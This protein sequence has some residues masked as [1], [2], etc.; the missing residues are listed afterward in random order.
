MIKL[1]KFI[2]NNKI[3]TIIESSLFNKNRQRK[4]A[5]IDVR[6]LIKLVQKFSRLFIRVAKKV[7]RRR[8][9]KIS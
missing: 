2:K 9:P 3:I 8:I 6:K 7:K 1:A 5:Q 4:Y